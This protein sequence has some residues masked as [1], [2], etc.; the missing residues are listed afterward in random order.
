MVELLCLF[1][2]GHIMTS[3]AAGAEL[4]FVN[5]RVTR[6]TVLRKPEK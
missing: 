2:V 1:P 3:L 6:H 5:I 4:S